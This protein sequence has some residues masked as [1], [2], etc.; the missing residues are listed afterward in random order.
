MRHRDGDGGGWGSRGVLAKGLAGL[1]LSVGHLTD[2]WTRTQGG[3]RRLL[4]RGR[5]Q[6][7]GVS[8][9]GASG[10]IESSHSECAH[11]KNYEEKLKS[12]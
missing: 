12:Q 5:V 6:S 7:G 1:R 2:S 11:G 3:H 10:L 9:Q 4:C 8:G